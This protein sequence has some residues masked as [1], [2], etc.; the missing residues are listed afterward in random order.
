MDIAAWCENRYTPVFRYLSH[1]NGIYVID[2]QW[3][4]LVILDACRY[5]L[6]QEMNTIAGTLSSRVSRGSD[7]AEFLLEN[8]TKYPKR[9]TFKDIVYIAGN[10]WTSSLLPNRF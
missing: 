9:T 10:A 1:G 5:D 4:N 8:F 3:D 2:E 6:F 7:T